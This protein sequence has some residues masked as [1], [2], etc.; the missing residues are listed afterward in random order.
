MNILAINPV[1]LKQ[2]INSEKVT[3]TQRQTPTGLQ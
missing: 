1:N 3:N 2:N